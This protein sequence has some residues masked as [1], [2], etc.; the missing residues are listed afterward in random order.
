MPLTYTPIVTYTVTSGTIADVSFSS[1][2]GYTDIVG[3]VNLIPTGSS[4]ALRAQIN[5]DANTIYS[6]TILY[7]TGSSATST[8]NTGMPDLTGQWGLSSGSNPL[9]FTFN[10]QNY[11]NTTTNKTVLWKLAD[12]ANGQ[13][14]ITASLYRSTSAI[15]QINYK[16]NNIGYFA[17]GSTFTLYGIKAA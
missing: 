17:V 12:N 6:R 9:T 4:N 2:S 3:V 15:T 7:G 8:R 11:S 1:I 16:T 5:N 13:V 10:Y 14:A